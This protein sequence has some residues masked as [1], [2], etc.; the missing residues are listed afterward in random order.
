VTP[1]IPVLLG[2][3]LDRRASDLHLTVGAPPT[4]RVDGHLVPLDEP[5]LDDAGLRGA[6]HALVGD[7]RR[8][9]FEREKELDLAYELP[10]RSRFRVNVFIQRGHI[11]A[12][13]RAIPTAI[14]DFDSLGL[15]ASVR[16]FASVPRGSP[17]RSRA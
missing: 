13:M 5:T 3:A 1:D 15:P 16:D 4:I 14:P 2:T 8:E 10:G 11:G 12:V 7:D 17:P 9:R 6:L